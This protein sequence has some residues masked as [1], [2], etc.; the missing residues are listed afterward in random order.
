[1]RKYIQLS[2]WIVFIAL[3]AGVL[4]YACSG[5]EEGQS[6][7]SA[8]AS[9][10]QQ[11]PQQVEILKY[12]DYSC[13][14]CKLYIPL[15]EQ[16]KQDFGDNISITYRHFPLSGF[17]HSE[18]AARAVEAAG[19]Q[20]MKKEMH[21]KVF[22]GQEVWS[23]GNAESIFMTYAEELGLNMEQFESDL[24]S[25][26]IRE[27]VES[28]RAEGQRRMVQSTPTYFINGQRIRQNPQN[29]QQFHSIVEMYM[30]Q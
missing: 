8:S 27:A 13:P 14:A 2:S 24:N 5:S 25:E 20:G 28:Q 22:D 26:R 23:N 1:M 3:S 17:Q 19:E 9:T 4:F 10:E 16:L 12:S 6:A 7:S 21:D 18:L 30:Y 15:E 11:Q 29:Y